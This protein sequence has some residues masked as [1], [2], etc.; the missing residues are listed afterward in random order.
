MHPLKATAPELIDSMRERGKRH[1]LCQ[2]AVVALVQQMAPHLRKH[3][4]SDVEVLSISNWIQIYFQT[5]TNSS[6]SVI[7]VGKMSPL[8]I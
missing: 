6:L 1:Q 7:T 8:E 2:A 5:Y 3:I 4:Q